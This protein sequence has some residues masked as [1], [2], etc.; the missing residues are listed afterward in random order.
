[1]V[2]EMDDH[3]MPWTRTKHLSKRAY[4]ALDNI[5]TD[6]EAWTLFKVAAFLETVGWTGLIVG[7]VADKLQWPYGPDILAVTGSVHGIFFVF[8]IF[9]VI[10]G[11]RSMGW[12]VWRFLFASLINAVPYGAM[13]LEMWVAHRRK[14]GKK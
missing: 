13:G 2:D 11:H 9:I 4:D 1:M 7:I 8:Y 14:Q 6:K 3:N 10:F 5:F 12:S